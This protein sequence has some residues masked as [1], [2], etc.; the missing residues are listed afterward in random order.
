MVLHAGKS[1][2]PRSSGWLLAVLVAFLAWSGGAGARS[3]LRIGF[4]DPALPGATP[5]R[6]AARQ[7]VPVPYG[8]LGTAGF[9]DPGMLLPH[10]DSPQTTC[11]LRH[12]LRSVELRATCSEGVL[13]LAGLTLL[14]ARLSAAIYC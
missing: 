9:I 1:R 7:G 10:A 6:N 4:V 12:E 2:L 3:L 11:D 8:R 13:G 5:R 14:R